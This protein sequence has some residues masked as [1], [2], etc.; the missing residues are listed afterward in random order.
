MPTSD[1]VV[2]SLR[3]LLGEKAVREEANDLLPNIIL[4]PESTEQVA[5]ILKLCHEAGQAIIP[6][7]GK[8]GLAQGIHKTGDEMG[9]S[10]ER[11]I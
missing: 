2:Q 10:M 1:H 8:S 6:I 5:A 3:K 4:K 7:G 9:L 11:M